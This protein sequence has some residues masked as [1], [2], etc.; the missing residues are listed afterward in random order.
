[1]Q[2][3]YDDNMGILPEMT[4][5]QDLSDAMKDTYEGGVDVYLAVCS[6]KSPAAFSPG[7]PNK[8]HWLVYWT[9]DL[10]DTP[11]E[12][13]RVLQVIK[14]IPSIR[15]ANW[16]PTTLDK[17]SFDEMYPKILQKIKIATYGLRDRTRWER[18]A[19]E[20]GTPQ[21]DFMNVFD[22]QVWVEDLLRQVVQAGLITPLHRG[23]I[24]DLAKD[25]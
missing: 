11:Q 19:N 4:R 1:M 24:V 25:V 20:T 5:P 22:S 17:E 16:G 8:K 18:A 15:Y 12:Y 23:Q 14:D 13:Y 6:R 9:L 3:I 7:A 2:T 21:Y 10:K